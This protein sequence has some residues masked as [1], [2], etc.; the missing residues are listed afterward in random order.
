MALVLEKLPWCLQKKIFKFYKFPTHQELIKKYLYLKLFR[1]KYNW[2]FDFYGKKIRL[3]SCDD[4]DNYLDILLQ[5]G[6]YSEKL[7]E[8]LSCIRIEQYNIHIEFNFADFVLYK[9]KQKEPSLLVK[10]NTIEDIFEDDEDDE[11]DMGHIDYGYSVSSSNNCYI[12]LQQFQ[13]ILDIFRTYITETERYINYLRQK[14]FA[15]ILQNYEG[16]M[17]LLTIF[18]DTDEV[19]HFNLNL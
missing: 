10:K 19:Q 11:D 18:V 14:I 16:K 1:L 15:L 4:I 12:E 3:F 9:I 6:N 2:V 17:V 5:D 13:N 7:N 8:L